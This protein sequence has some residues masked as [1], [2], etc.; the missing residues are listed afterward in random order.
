MR[1]MVRFFFWFDLIDNDARCTPVYP[2]H[3][4]QNIVQLPTKPFRRTHIDIEWTLEKKP[5]LFSNL[6]IGKRRIHTYSEVGI[7]K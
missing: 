6:S 3:V 5:A 7:E 2:G 4:Q 1:S